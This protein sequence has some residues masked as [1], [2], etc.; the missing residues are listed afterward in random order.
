MMIMVQVVNCLKIITFVR[1]QTT[2]VE[3][4]DN[5]TGCELLKNHYLCKVTNNIKRRKQAGN[6]VVNCLKIITF[7]R[8]QTTLRDWRMIGQQL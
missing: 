4:D 5:G 7:V 2:R 6:I 3:Y 1:S 8:S